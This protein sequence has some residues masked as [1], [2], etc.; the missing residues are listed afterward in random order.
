MAVVATACRLRCT[1]Y[2]IPPI[3]D[4]EVQRISG[5]IIPALAT[6]T[7]L[8]AGMVSLEVMKVASE[9]LRQREKAQPEPSES[10]LQ[11]DVLTENTQETETLKL[12]IDDKASHDKGIIVRGKRYLQGLAHKLLHLPR[13][14][15]RMEEKSR[16]K[17]QIKDRPALMTTHTDG[18]WEPIASTPAADH[19]RRVRHRWLGYSSTYVE[20][21]EMEGEKQRLLRRFRNAYVNLALPI[22]S[23]TQ[24]VPASLDVYLPSEAVWPSVTDQLQSLLAKDSGEE[25]DERSDNSNPSIDIRTGILVSLWDEIHVPKLLRF[26][27]E[28][29]QYSHS[30]ASIAKLQKSLLKEACD[31][32]THIREITLR[33]L[34]M[35]LRRRFPTIVD[36]VSVTMGEKAVL[37][38]DF[39]PDREELLWSTLSTLIGSNTEDGVI[40][41]AKELLLPTLQSARLTVTVTIQDP[42]D[43]S[44][45][46]DADISL[47]E[48]TLPPVIVTYLPDVEPTRDTLEGGDS[49]VDDKE[50][51]ELRG[52]QLQ[53]GAEDDEEE[54]EQVDSASF[55]FSSLLSDSDL[56]G[57]LDESS[58]S[59]LSQNESAEDEDLYPEYEDVVEQEISEVFENEAVIDEM[60]LIVDIDKEANTEEDVDVDVD[61][62][63]EC[64]DNVSTNVSKFVKVGKE[65]PNRQKKTW[66][67]R[68]NSLKSV[69][70]M[71]FSEEDSDR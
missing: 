34:M 63:E 61:E 58:T 6:S 66:K 29:D 41:E 24:P 15:T 57:Q 67:E 9:I 3:D 22:L 47:Q 56:D 51:E 62:D 40:S 70:R 21:Q 18:L 64:I 2:D 48:I 36:F 26:P 39:L 20:T 12:G 10:C 30:V 16:G 44:A 43:E 33:D 35:Y 65:T 53:Q 23:F 31:D 7:S 14:D 4:L 1:N 8:I 27:E 50:Q 13:K 28:L 42:M 69:S 68:W 52:E 17:I 54:G 71:I 59:G 46:D 19:Y 49:E 37:Y 5:N 45:V 55:E 11:P 25:D 32:E 60:E 38:A